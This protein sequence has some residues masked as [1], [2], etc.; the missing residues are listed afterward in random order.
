MATEHINVLQDA[1]DEAESEIETVAR[2]SIGSDIY[3]IAQSYGFVDADQEE[4]ISPRDW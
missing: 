4:L 3:F 1:F 2:E